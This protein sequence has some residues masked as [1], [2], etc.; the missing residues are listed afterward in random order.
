[1]STTPT[2]HLGGSHP[3]SLLD[4]ATGAAEA[5]RTALAA[6]ARIEPNARDYQGR[7]FDLRAARDAHRDRLRRIDGVLSEVNALAEAIADARMA[8]Q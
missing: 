7:N 5:L 1:M 2:I 8:G 6:V 3:E 4:A